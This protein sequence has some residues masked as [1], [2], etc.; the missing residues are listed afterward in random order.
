M[1]MPDVQRL[2]DMLTAMQQQ[3]DTALNVV[4]MAQAEIASLKRRIDEL[5]AEL[6]QLKSEDKPNG[7]DHAASDVAHAG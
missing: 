3:R 5:D 2:R 7:S 4:V 6:D 1:M